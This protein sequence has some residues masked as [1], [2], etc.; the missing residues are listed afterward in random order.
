MCLTFRRFNILYNFS[1][2]C[3]EEILEFVHGLARVHFAFSIVQGVSA[4]ILK[5]GGPFIF[6][7]ILTILYALNTIALF[8]F[9]QNPAT[10][11]LILP[12]VF[13][14]AIGFLY[15]YVF[16]TNILTLPTVGAFAILLVVF[17]SSLALFSLILA[18]VTI[19]ILV[20]LP[21][22]LEYNE[23]DILTVEMLDT[24]K[25]DFLDV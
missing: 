11:T 7:V 2:T 24:I 23:G 4:S 19:A 21:G 5:S 20:K 18:V 10:T 6:E 22:K 25:N 17:E 12:V 9:V 16:I 3:I 14:A 15:G 1:S 8:Y 13:Q